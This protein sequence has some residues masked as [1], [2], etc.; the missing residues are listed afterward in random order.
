MTSQASPESVRLIGDWHLALSYGCANPRLYLALAGAHLKAAPKRE[1]QR[2][3]LENGLHGDPTV[4]RAA[5]EQLAPGLRTPAIRPYR[6]VF[7][8]YLQNYG[9][10]MLVP[11]SLRPAPDWSA[12]D[13][14]RGFARDPELSPAQGLMEL[15]RQV[16]DAAADVLGIRVPIHWR[17]ALACSVDAPV[18]AGAIA[19]NSLQ[20]PLAVALMREFCALPIGRG[21]P[22]QVPFG[23]QPVFCTGDVSARGGFGEAGALT[24]KLSAFVREAGAG[25]PAILTA[26]QA[27]ALEAR[28]DARQWLAQVQVH[29]ADSLSDLLRLPEFAAGLEVLSSPPNITELDSL[30]TE[31]NRQTGRLRFAETREAACWLL[32]Y[33]ASDAYRLRLSMLAGMP[34]LHEGRIAEARVHLNEMERLLRE[35]TALLGADVCAEAAASLASESIDLAEPELGLRLVRQVLPRHRHCSIPKRVM[36]FGAQSETLRA[37]GRW[38]A[39]VR[40]AEQ[41]VELARTGFASEAGRDMNYLA[42]AL[43]RRAANRPRTRA[44]DLDRAA[45]VLTDAAGTWAPLTAARETHLGFCIQFEAELARLRGTPYDPGH[46]PPWQ[47]TWRHPYLFALLACSRNPAHGRDLRIAFA[48]RTIA[49]CDGLIQRFG[50][51][52]FQVMGLIYRTGYA[53]QCGD[54]PRHWAAAIQDWCADRERA[55][56]PGWRRRLARFAELPAPAGRQKWVDGLY[57]AVP[58]H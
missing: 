33:A 13:A 22:A 8:V 30:V 32:P 55:A 44:A 47:G 20:V 48:Q 51:G 43:L 3:F 2:V 14:F 49:F 4:L 10:G 53:V 31:M 28:A 52:I 9:I 34:L 50:P 21:S 7:P 42:H 26:G 1:L 39:A 58:H 40:S 17:A 23:A 11:F 24:H 27:R 12:S 56:M 25:H 35:E 41:A 37:L 19:G 29:L 36:L 5:W 16:E 57:D 6:H 46:E 45:V 15:L 38:D 54:D 18:H